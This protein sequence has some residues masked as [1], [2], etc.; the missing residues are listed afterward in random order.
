MSSKS[1]HRVRHQSHN[2]VNLPEQQALM[3]IHQTNEYIVIPSSSTPNYSSYFTIDIREKGIELHNITLQFNVTCSITGGTSARLAPCFFWFDRIDF[4]INGTVFDTYFPL[5]QFLN[6]H[7]WNWEE[8]QGFSNTGAGSYASTTGRVTLSTLG[9]ANDWYL[10][11]FTF[12]D[13]TH[14]V[15][16]YPKDDIQIRV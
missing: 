2:G 4:V 8:D 16:L 11:L 7:L 14:P 6:A 1:L 5:E 12:I 3:L 15:L 9:V 13:S 10:P